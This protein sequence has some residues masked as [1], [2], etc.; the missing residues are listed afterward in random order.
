MPV[1]HVLVGGQ[2][3]GIELGD[4]AQGSACLPPGGAV[5]LGRRPERSCSA[6][7]RAVTESVVT[8]PHLRTAGSSCGAV[9]RP[10]TAHLPMEAGPGRYGVSFTANRRHSSGTPLRVR[11]PR[12][13]NRIPDP[14]TRS[15]TTLDTRVSPGPASDMILE[16]T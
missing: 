6:K 10:L 3:I 1:S 7:R 15:F 2:P 4:D 5:Q 16:P 8:C 13:S 12:S 14:A 9:R 11:V